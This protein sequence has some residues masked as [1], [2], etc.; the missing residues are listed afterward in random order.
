MVSHQCGVSSIKSLICM[1]SHQCG[2]W[3]RIV[4]APLPDSSWVRPVVV[5]VMEI[6]IIL[7]LTMT[8]MVVIEG[9]DDGGCVTRV[10]CQCGLLSV[11][12]LSSG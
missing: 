8:M 7:T 3:S 1:V 2:L 11:C 5:V 6:I 4:S 12:G 9:D 10:V